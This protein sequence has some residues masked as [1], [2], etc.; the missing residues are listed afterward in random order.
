MG[1]GLLPREKDPRRVRLG[2]MWLYWTRT[3]ADHY[4]PYRGFYPDIDIDYGK[5]KSESQARR[6]IITFLKK[7]LPGRYEVDRR[8]LVWSIE[9]SEDDIIN[10]EWYI[11]KEQLEELRFRCHLHPGEERRSFGYYSLDK[12]NPTTDTCS[13]W[14]INIVNDVLGKELIVCDNPKRLKSVKEALEKILEI[15]KLK[16]IEK[17]RSDKQ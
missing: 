16:D 4:P 11:T 3:E 2:H 10:V 17:K 1:V 13:S 9:L 7:G 6:E 12:N 8:A 15:R 5:Y 14:V